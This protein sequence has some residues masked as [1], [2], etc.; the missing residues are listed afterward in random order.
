MV[1]NG[2]RITSPSD[3]EGILESVRTG[4]SDE[5]GLFIKGFYPNGRTEYYAINLAD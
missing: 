5:Q 3:V 4:N 1:I 2:N